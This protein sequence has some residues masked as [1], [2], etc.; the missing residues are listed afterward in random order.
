VLLKGHKWHRTAASSLIYVPYFHRTCSTWWQYTIHRWE[1]TQMKDTGFW[2]HFSKEKEDKLVRSST[3]WVWAYIC[4]ITQKISRFP[5]TLAKLP[6]HCSCF[7]VCPAL[8]WL[9]QSPAPLNHI[10]CLS[11]HWPEFKLLTELRNTGS[12]QL[13]ELM[14]KIQPSCLNCQSS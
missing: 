7:Q 13:K 8:R 11:S 4:S 14:G 3:Q 1:R 2:V 5:S 9:P 12:Y 6:T 10:F